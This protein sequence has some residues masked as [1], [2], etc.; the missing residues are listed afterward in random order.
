MK[1]FCIV[2]IPYYCSLSFFTVAYLAPS[3]AIASHTAGLELTYRHT[4][5]G[6]YILHVALYRDCFGIAAPQS[7]TVYATSVACGVNTS[8][9]LPAMPG[10]GTEVSL[11]CQS[12]FSTCQGGTEPGFQKWEYE[13]TISLTA[14][15]PD[16]IFEEQE[17]CMWGT[18]I[19]NASNV[20]VKATLD[21]SVTDNSSPQFTND[22]ILIP[23]I[24]QYY[25]Y[26]NGMTDAEGDSLVYHLVDAIG[27]IYNPPY[28]G[29]HPFTSA[30]PVTF[31]SISGDYIMT[32]TAVESGPLVF[33][34]KDYRNGIL[35]GS[36]MRCLL[37]KM[38]FCSNVMPAA[39]GMN[40]TTQQ[41]AY[42]FPDDT[43]CF[44]ILTG[45]ADAAQDVTLTWNNGIPAGA[46]TTTTGM[47]DTGTFCWTP[48]INDLRS[49]PYMFTATVRDNSCPTNGEGV[50][51]YLIYVTLDSSLV[52]LNVDAT[53]AD[54]VFSV[55]P[56]PSTGLIRLQTSS[57]ISG[58]KI[59][60]AL[61]KCI[62]DEK[63]STS[64]DISIQP[65]GP[66]YLEAFTV[67]GKVFRK[68]FIRQ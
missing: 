25:H 59:F 47:R 51:S 67:D 52:F 49:Q 32:P 6:Q 57:G 65:P 23:C 27:A 38:T 19:S 11:T 12:A 15:C 8:F 61:G 17:C 20:V 36:V 33:E 34:I 55:F 1:S 16:W 29:Q 43:I 21:N 58:V 35:M 53:E 26:N 4:T 13:D 44:D 9:V 62:L 56:N 45:D 41:V 5:G 66:Y 14:Q 24:N 60:D 48:G 10:T 68:I 42:V 18:T 37:I 3:E 64:I 31:D 22:P 28:S 54:N 63:N 46:F 2:L 40:G 30:P 50:Y 39:S 7:V